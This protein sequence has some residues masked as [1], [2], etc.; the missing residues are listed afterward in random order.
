MSIIIDT[1]TLPNTYKSPL[2]NGEFYFY[3]A[4]E[5]YRFG[6]DNSRSVNEYRYHTRIYKNF[7]NNDNI[8]FESY[9][10]IEGNG[11]LNDPTITGSP[12]GETINLE[13]NNTYIVVYGWY[14]DVN[15]SGAH[16]ILQDAMKLNFLTIENRLPL[17]PWTITTVINRLLDV[18][19]PISQGE[20]PRFV[21]NGMGEDGN[22]IPEGQEGSGQAAKFD[23]INA[24]QFS[25]TKQTLREC[26]QEIGKV[27]HGEPR[28]KPVKATNTDYAAY[29]GYY[30]EVSF[31]EYGGQAVSNIARR[32]YAKREI[33]YGVANYCSSIDSHAENLVNQL[34]KFS[35]TITEP[36]AGGYRTLRTENQYVRVQED[37]CFIPTQKEIYTIGEE[38]AS[39]GQNRVI[40]GEI[41]YTRGGETFTYKDIDITPYVFE[42]SIYDVQCSSYDS[43]FPY[44]KAYALY[45]VQGE[46]NIYGLNFKQQDPISDVFQRYAIINI[47]RAATG[48]S[49]LNIDGAAIPQLAFRVTYTPFYTARIAQSK[50]NVKDK[51][52]SSTLIYNQSSNIIE[53]KYFGEALKGVVARMGTIEKAYTYLLSNVK[54]IPKAGEK[55]D[56]DYY[57]STVAT[58]ILPT[59]FKVT[60]GLSK[61]FNR[62]SQYI[63]INSQ[64]RYSEVSR[65]QAVESNVLYRNYILVGEREEADDNTF[66]SQYFMWAIDGTFNPEEGSDKVL[67]NVVAIGLSK[68]LKENTNIQLPVISAAFGNSISFSWSYQDNYSAGPNLQYKEGGVDNNTVSGYFQND[69]PYGDFY[70]RIY[71]YNFALSKN[72][73][74]PQNNADQQAIGNAL[75]GFVGGN[76]AP[77]FN[78]YIKTPAGHYY[79]LRKDN[80]EVL[81]VNVQIDFVT[82]D[83]N[84]IIGSGLAALNPTVHG[85]DK[86][87]DLTAMLY[88]FD[89][90]LNKFANKITGEFPELETLSNLGGIK[91]DIGPDTTGNGNVVKLQARENFPASGK[92]WAIVTNLYKTAKQVEGEDGQPTTVYQ[93]YGGDI[94]L[95]KNMNV[96]AGQAFTPIYFTPKHEVFD[97]TV[98]YDKK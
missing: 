76:A 79:V 97:N 27:I 52:I 48:D 32:R 74:I 28:I 17:K 35:G 38:D 31:D 90:P 77:R 89:K 36:Y 53:T 73:T 39:D 34:D 62:L 92:S 78:D 61:D 5:L 8:I 14:E 9:Y 30:F 84:L 7:E 47:L 20:K 68:N 83:E 88:V 22:I 54:Q 12:N 3:S 91:V 11:L 59:C 51:P 82:K 94:L 49:E 93:Y 29:G 85:Y 72:G 46:K 24:P 1:I 57:I 40:C 44:S 69:M 58:E 71:Y 70:G 37:N 50:V 10:H 6:D 4:R 56:N 86:K 67:T 87:Q 55:F 80:R 45:Y 13:P 42:K 15:F 75:P 41:S 63:G 25:F 18:C 19:E 66:I 96:S 16:S 23:K 60:I 33:S 65:T 2:N 81:Q 98:W 26:L 43:Q 21:L 64:K 95:A